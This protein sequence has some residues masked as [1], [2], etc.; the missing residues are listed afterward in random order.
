MH[1]CCTKER[2]RKEVIHKPCGDCYCGCG[3]GYPGSDE[4]YPSPDECIYGRSEGFKEE[5]T[6]QQGEVVCLASKRSRQDQPHSLR[7]PGNAAQ[8]AF[9]EEV[10][11]YIKEARTD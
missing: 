8:M 1:C 2:L 3:R 10:A 7:R 6:A 5:M 11:E 9:V 4:G